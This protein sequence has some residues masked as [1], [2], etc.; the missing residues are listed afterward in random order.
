MVDVRTDA[1]GSADVL[2]LQ[3]EA[4]GKTWAHWKLI[5]P[6]LLFLIRE[7]WKSG[8]TDW[9]DVHLCVRGH[10]ERP[11]ELDQSKIIVAPFHLIH[12]I[13]I[14]YHN[15]LSSPKSS[16]NW[17]F[18][19]TWI[20]SGWP[21]AFGWGAATTQCT[22]QLPSDHTGRNWSCRYQS[23]SLLVSVAFFSF[24]SW[25]RSLRY[26]HSAPWLDPAT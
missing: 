16:W 7:S 17:F 23:N 2:T 8:E 5:C 11:V 14:M 6:T 18:V 9:V 4:D 26:R 13:T 19:Q 15:S 22:S 20:C 10:V 24:Y 3:T 12:V 21:D 25:V 1:I